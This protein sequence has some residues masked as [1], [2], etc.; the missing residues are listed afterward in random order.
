[1]GSCGVADGRRALGSRHID[2]D[3]PQKFSRLHRNLNASVAAI[4]T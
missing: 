4:A 3:L 1:M 2:H